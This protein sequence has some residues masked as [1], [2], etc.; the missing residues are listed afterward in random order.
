[1]LAILLEDAK[2]I[3]I[4]AIFEAYIK[5]AIAIE[6]G[7]ASMFDGL[8]TKSELLTLKLNNYGRQAESTQQAKP[9]LQ[10]DGESKGDRPGRFEVSGQQ[11]EQQQGEERRIEQRAKVIKCSRHPT[12]GD[13]C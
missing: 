9:S 8:M 3:E 4:R 10:S 13:R 7:Q 6:S 1:M 11:N 12:K 5:E 2:D